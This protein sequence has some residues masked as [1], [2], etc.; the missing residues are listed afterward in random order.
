MKGVEGA[1]KTL[2]T[3]LA[4]KDWD[5]EGLER[6]GDEEEEEEEE[7]GFDGDG[8]ALRPLHERLPLRLG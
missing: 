7:R 8:H 4:A 5:W 6:G 1:C 3:A 2:C